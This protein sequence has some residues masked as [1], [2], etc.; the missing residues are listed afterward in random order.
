[1]N[2]VSWIS[3]SLLLWGITTMSTMGQQF[4]TEHTIAGDTV[5]SSMSLDEFTFLAGL[6]Q[7]NG[8]W[9]VVLS[10]SNGRPRKPEQ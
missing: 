5:T 7:G 1:M 6:W 10:K 9:W 2:V 8:W 3:L 4:L